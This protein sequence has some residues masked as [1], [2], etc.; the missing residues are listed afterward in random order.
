MSLPQASVPR[1]GVPSVLTG[2]L[3][4]DEQLDHFRAALD[5]NTTLGEV[6]ERACGLGVPGWSLAA[7]ALCQTVWN[8][9]SGF[10]P[11]A[12]IRD[13]DLVYFDGAEVSWDAEDAVIQAG[14]LR[15]ADLHA[16]VEI[17][18]QARVH[19]WYEDKF[20][21]PCQPYDCTEAAIDTFP[22]TATCVGVRA[23]ADGHRSVYAPFGLSDMF[24]MVV[25][26]NTAL[27]PQRV[28]EAKA[29]RW[30]QRWPELSVLPWPAGE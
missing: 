24:N 23:D 30:Q 25:R 8:V 22:T 10:P 16:E 3:P 18:N 29:T 17:R 4:L 5:Q 19:L 12:G 28:Y 9:I 21:L 27:C 15:F 20:G 1:M 7:G 6:L 26:P 13:Y 14:R 11:D 2:R